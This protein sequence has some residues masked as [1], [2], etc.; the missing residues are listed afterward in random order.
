MQPLEGVFIAP[1][2]YVARMKTKSRKQIMPSF[3]A[4]WKRI[5]RAECEIVKD[6]Q[7]CADVKY[8]KKYVLMDA[9]VNGMF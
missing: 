6:R 8:M 5:H 9:Q 4:A 7:M 3:P 1:R 2:S